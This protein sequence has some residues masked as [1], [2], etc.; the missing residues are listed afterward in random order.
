MKYVEAKVED[1]CIFEFQHIFKPIFFLCKGYDNIK[2]IL[3]LFDFSALSYF[4]TVI[5]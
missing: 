2:S 1:M 5:K 3:Q 4:Q